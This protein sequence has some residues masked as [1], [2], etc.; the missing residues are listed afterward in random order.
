MNKI[1]FTFLILSSV[2][3]GLFGCNRTDFLNEK[4]N[5]AMV[6]PHSFDHY[7]ALLDRDGP[8][9]GGDGRGLT[10]QLGESFADNYYLSDADF[11]ANLPAEKQN[12]YLWKDQ[13]YEG[14]DVLDWNYPYSAV[15]ICNTVLDGLERMDSEQKNS[16]RFNYI[17][18][19]ALFHR[20]HMYYNL[21]QVFCPPFNKDGANTETGIPLRDGSDM[22]DH[23]YLAS[24]G[25]NYSRILE[26]LHAATQL[27]P[28]DD[29]YKTR[30]SK[31][32]GYGML[33]RAYLTMREYEL[34]GKYADSCLAIR[35]GLMDYN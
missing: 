23:P 29:T 17:K 26:D 32:A 31:Q 24:V 4:P 35:S 15:L 34:A 2:C 11:F 10:P 28:T 12:Y 1:K 19:Q 8:M 13:P 18:A 9:N 16:E 7:Q 14:G 21:A 22:N 27:L 33:A 5:K 30:P 25:E 6:I 20:A 3:V